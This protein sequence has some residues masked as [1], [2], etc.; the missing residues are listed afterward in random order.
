MASPEPETQMRL[1]TLT[2]LTAAVASLAAAPAALAQTSTVGSSAGEPTMNICALGF[3]CTYI[4]FQNGKPTDVVK[5]TGTVTSWSLNA[6]SQGG[7]VRLRVLRPVAGGNLMAIRSSALRTVSTTGLNTFPAHLAVRKG[8]VLALSN[9][10]SGI[11]MAQSAPGT[12]IHYFSNPFSDGS[13]G[14]P[15]RTAMQLHLLLSAK[16]HS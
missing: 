12:S 2:A 11:Y 5:R 14:A 10:S 9:D 8:D 13:T 6:G 3:N 15:D 7:Q 1:R 16:L 4:N